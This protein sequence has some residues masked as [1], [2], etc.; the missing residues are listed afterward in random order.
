MRIGP[1]Y[2]CIICT[3]EPQYISENENQEISK[4]FNMSFHINITRNILSKITFCLLPLFLSPELTCLSLL[5]VSLIQYAIFD[6]KKVPLLFQP[7]LHFFPL[8]QTFSPFLI[9]STSIPT[10]LPD[11]SPVHILPSVPAVWFHILTLIPYPS[12]SLSM[13]SLFPVCIVSQ[14]GAIHSPH[15]PVIV[16]GS[17]TGVT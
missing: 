5:H 7:I 15:G 17:Y 10:V 13:L 4:S 16:S 3:T 2:S 14:W 12:I 9:F 8:P 1:K 11:P 6:Q